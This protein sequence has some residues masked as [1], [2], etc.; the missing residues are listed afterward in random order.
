[1][2]LDFLNIVPEGAS[3]ARLV[4]NQIGRILFKKKLFIDDLN[5]SASIE[6]I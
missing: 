1:M 6:K 2:Y 3:E 5:T 4:H